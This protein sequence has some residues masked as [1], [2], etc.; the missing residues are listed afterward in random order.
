[1]KKLY[2]FLLI[3]VF[4][5]SISAQDT[6]K[7]D[8]KNSGKFFGEVFF[9]YFY[10]ANSDTIYSSTGGQYQKNKK[11]DNAFALR[12][13]Y[14]GYKHKFNE[15]FSTK[16]MFEGNDGQLLTNGKK[17]VNIKYY[18]LKW[19]NIFP[20]SDLI[21]GGQSTP[22][23]SRFTEKIWGYRSV[24]KTIMDFRKQGSSNDFGI[25]LSGKLNEDKTI[26]YNLMIGNGSGQKPE[27]NVFKKIYAS[28][29]AKLFDK[30]LLL[31]LYSDFEPGEN[32]ETKTTIKLFVGFQ[33]DKLTV[34]V[35][36]FQKIRKR[37]NADAEKTLGSTFFVRGT[38][39]DKKLYGFGRFDIFNPD[40]SIAH[41]NE[42][43][44]VIGFDYTPF[45]NVHFM[46]NVWLNNYSE[47]DNSTK[48]S[49]DIVGRLTFWFKF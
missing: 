36:P 13:F 40:K 9:D 37:L 8:F 29:N 32:S 10:K 44:T 12:R 16:L 46:P 11:S 24:E 5:N 45:K 22:T 38:L 28:V 18:Y 25:S 4:A 42:R 21:V 39:I 43:F 41:Y 33:N 34:G 35:E 6:K 48:R 15:Q 27:A 2:F 20:G 3:S 14:F 19:K 7:L 17:S 23:W 26:G 49:G 30:K 31:E 47:L 1:M